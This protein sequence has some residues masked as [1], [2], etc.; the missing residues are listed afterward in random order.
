MRW[1]AVLLATALLAPRG[2]RRRGRSNSPPLTD[3]QAAKR[4]KH[5]SWEPRPGNRKANRHVLTKRQLKTFRAKSDMPY[6]A[7]VTGRYRGTT[8]EI[9]QWAAAKH[10]IDV[11]VMRAVA[12]IESWWRMSTVG[13]NG[14]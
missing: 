2:P 4:V 11:D 3:A 1:L 14:D 9:I 8:D 13:D 6:K 7:R 5:S 12:V 10:G